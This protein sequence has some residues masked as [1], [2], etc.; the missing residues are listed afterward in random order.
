VKRKFNWDGEYKYTVVEVK[1]NA[2]RDAL[3]VILKD[4]KG[5]SLVEEIPEVCVAIIDSFCRYVR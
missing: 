4:V 2:L 5:L 3:Q 1:S